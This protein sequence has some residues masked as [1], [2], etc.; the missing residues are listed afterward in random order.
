MSN[1]IKQPTVTVAP[2]IVETTVTVSHWLDG[3]FTD[4]PANIQDGLL[5]ALEM[6]AEELQCPMTIVQAECRIDHDFAEGQPGYFYLHVIA[7]EI[8][9]ADERTI[10]PENV[11]KKWIQ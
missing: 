1:V 2:R 11:V 10:D 4:W 7:S 6:K 9:M 5:I 3:E 8:V